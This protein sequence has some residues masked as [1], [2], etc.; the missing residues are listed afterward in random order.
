MRMLHVSSMTD[1]LPVPPFQIPEPMDT[2]PD[3][4]QRE[5][6]MEGPLDLVLMPGLGFE[7]NGHRLGR[8][9]GYYDAF[10]D[11]LLRRSTEKVWLLPVLCCALRNMHG[12]CAR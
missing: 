6:C 12:L 7:A 5:D 11:R 9:G 4:Q 8:G 1:C 2:Y 3:G 10:V